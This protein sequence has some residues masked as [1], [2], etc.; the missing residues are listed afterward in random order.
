MFLGRNLRE[1]CRLLRKDIG[2]TS[3]KQILC[4]QTMNQHQTILPNYFTGYNPPRNIVDAKIR[5]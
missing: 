3:V 1:E 2:I 5:K 4:S